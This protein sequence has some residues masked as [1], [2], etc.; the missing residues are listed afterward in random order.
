MSKKN[1]EEWVRIIERA[2]A[3]D[4]GQV[5]SLLWVRWNVVERGDAEGRRRVDERIKDCER[6][7][8]EL[9]ESIA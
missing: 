4:E 8:A 5:E 2:I 9:K 1:S 3:K 6:N 7:I